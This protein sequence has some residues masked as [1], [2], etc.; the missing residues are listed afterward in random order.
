MSMIAWKILFNFFM[1]LSTALFVRNSHILPGIYF[2][3][4]NNVLD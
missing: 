3:F 2:I 4:L 1:S